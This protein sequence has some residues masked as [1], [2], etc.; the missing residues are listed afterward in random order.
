M[1]ELGS[2]KNEQPST[3]MSHATGTKLLHLSKGRKDSCL[4]H[5][6]TLSRMSVSD[7]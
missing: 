4:M 1:R 5:I 7:A 6:G 2:M 3:T